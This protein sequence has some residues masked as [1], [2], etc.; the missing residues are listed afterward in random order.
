MPQIHAKED[1]ISLTASVAAPVF[2][3][4]DTLLQAIGFALTGS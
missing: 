1:E 3:E 4:S 2:A